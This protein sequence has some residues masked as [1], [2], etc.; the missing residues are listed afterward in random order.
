MPSVLYWKQ[1]TRV[2]QPEGIRG[3]LKW[4][5]RAVNERWPTLEEPIRA[6]L[7]SRSIDWHSPLRQDD[8]AEYRDGDFLEL[9]GQARLRWELSKFWP[10]RGPQWDALG[11][12]GDGKVILI[13]AKAHVGEM[14]TSATQASAVSRE[15]IVSSLA[16]CAVRLKARAGHAEWS[17]HFYQLSN[18]LAHL[19]FLLDHG[20]PARLVLVNFLNDHEMDGPSTSEAW[21]A[22]YQVAFHVL[23]LGSRHA[24]SRYILHV[25]PDVA[26]VT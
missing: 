21:D 7:G 9:V 17:E 14:C 5:Q 6:A 11:V 25:Y 22:A 13:E 26:E 1:M 19:Q 3:S 8:F 12:T 24:L 4:I 15:L 23:G 16:A 18:R 20:V 2:A 10:S